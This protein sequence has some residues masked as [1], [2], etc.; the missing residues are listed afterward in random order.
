MESKGIQPTAVTQEILLE[1]CED[2]RQLVKYLEWFLK[3]T[4]IVPTLNTWI[5]ILK[6]CN[7]L[8]CEDL[9]TEVSLEVFISK[10]CALGDES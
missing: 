5:C 7:A 2:R 3:P 9:V 4:N 8:N 1:T 10:N 6:K